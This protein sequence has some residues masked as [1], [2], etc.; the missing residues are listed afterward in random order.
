MAEVERAQVQLG[1]GA[2]LS[3]L[4][5]FLNGLAILPEAVQEIFAQLQASSLGNTQQFRAR[6]EL[7]A[8][9]FIQGFQAELAG[10]RVGGADGLAGA[11]T[12]EIFGANQQ[13]DA[14]TA[15]LRL[16]SALMEDLR[17][18][19]LPALTQPAFSAQAVQGLQAAIGGANSA[20]ESLRA[21]NSQL[22]EVEERLARLRGF[23]LTTRQQERFLTTAGTDGGQTIQVAAP[24]RR[25]IEAAG[26]PVP[27]LTSPAIQALLTTR[28]GVAGSVNLASSGR[29]LAAVLQEVAAQQA[30]VIEGEFVR[31]SQQSLA[32]ARAVPGSALVPTG[33]FT[34]S[35]PLTDQQ[36]ARLDEQLARRNAQIARRE[37]RLERI[38]EA[39][40]RSGLTDVRLGDTGLTTVVPST[41]VARSAI[42]NAE[43]RRF[44]REINTQVLQ[45]LDGQ[46]QR[47]L[48]GRGPDLSPGALRAQLGPSAF[49]DLILGRGVGPFQARRLSAEQINALING[50]ANGNQREAP[51]PRSGNR[52]FAPGLL[53]EG[54]ARAELEAQLSGFG[55]PLVTP[56][57]REI[58]ERAAAGRE[59]LN[60]QRQIRQLALT[61]GAP[62]G[63]LPVLFGQQEAVVRSALLRARAFDFSRLPRVLPPAP[64]TP[65]E[66]RAEREYEAA[67][68]ANARRRRETELRANQRLAPPLPR[69]PVPQFSN[70]A[71]Q[72]AFA[73]G[74]SGLD[75]EDLLA[76][77]TGETFGLPRADVVARGPRGGLT[78][79]V[80]PEIL[81]AYE[82]GTQ[83]AGQEAEFLARRQAELARA[84]EQQAVAAREATLAARQLLSASSGAIALPAAGVSNITS[85]VPTGRGNLAA[86]QEA[87]LLRQAER[88][89]INERSLY[90]QL[91]GAVRPASVP[92]GSIGFG[93]SFPGAF[94]GGQSFFL[95]QGIPTSI[96][97][98]VPG[99]PGTPGNP[100][101]ITTVGGASGANI[102][103]PGGGGGPA[104]GGPGGG[105]PGGP[106]GGLPGVPRGGGG[107]N[108][109]ADFRANFFDG[110]L[111][112]NDGD[113][114]RSLGQTVRFS[115]L[116]GA[117]YTALFQFT[118]AIRAGVQGAIEFEQ[119]LV[120]LSFATGRTTQEVTPFANAAAR[121]A[122]NAGLDGQL[123]VT[124]A[125][126]AV[127]LLGLSGAPLAQQRAGGLQ[128]AEIAS[129][130]AR[131]SG[132]KD[133][134]LVLTQL[135]G[136]AK[137]FGEPDL[138]KI[139]DLA[140]FI[141]RTSGT[142]PGDL[143]GA[144]AEIGG[145]AKNAGFSLAETLALISKLK[146]STA[147]T[148]NA[149]AGNLSQIFSRA[150]QGELERGL[151]EV[152]VNTF[153]TTLRDQ[154]RQLS[155]LPLT[156]EQENVLAG[157][158]GRGRSGNAVLNALREFDGITETAQRAESSSG[159]LKKA[160]DAL[161]ETLGGRLAIFAT[162]LKQLSVDIA[163]SGLLDVFAGLLIAATPLVKVLDD[164]VLA[165]DALP[166]ALRDTALA[167]GAL[168]LVAGSARARA[169]IAG[170]AT[171]LPGL[172]SGTGSALA[173]GSAVTAARGGRLAGSGARGRFLGPL[174]VL[175]GAFGLFDA[176]SS[177]SN[178]GLSLG[179]I[180]R[181]AGSGAL[182][183][184]SVGALG[185][186][187]PVVGE[188]TTLVG[189]I[190]GAIVGG[191]STGLAGLFGNRQAGN[192]GL[193]IPDL[194]RQGRLPAIA[195]GNSA[196]EAA[197][198]SV[199]GAGRSPFTTDPDD[200]GNPYYTLGLKRD[201][202]TPIAAKPRG[203]L[204]DLLLGPLGGG[205]D[206]GVT[207][208][209]DLTN[210]LSGLSARQ[211]ARLKAIADGL[212]ANAKVFQDF[213][214][215]QT[216]AQAIAE[217]SRQG[218]TGS[219]I[220]KAF[221][222]AAAAAREAGLLTNSA[223]TDFIAGVQ[224]V[225]AAVGTDAATASGNPL[226]NPL[227]Q[228]D[229]ID[230]S[231][232]Q[233]R[234]AG[235][236]SQDLAALNLV[237]RQVQDQLNA[238]D[239][240]Q[241]GA[242]GARDVSL[243][244]PDDVAGRI[245]IQLGVLQRQ[246]RD[247][248]DPG[249]QA[250]IDA[251]INDLVRQQLENSRAITT[252]RRAAGVDPTSAL[253]QARNNLR[254]AKDA[255]AQATAGQ[256]AY[257]Q[258]LRDLRAAQ[259]ALGNEELAQANRL[260]LLGIDRTNPVLVAR[261]AVRAAEDRLRR[262]RARGAGADTIAQDRLDLGDA[263]SQAEAAAFQQRFSDAQTAE[264]LGRTSHLAYISYLNNE[265]DRLTAIKNRT[266]QQQEQLNQVDQAL[267]SA[268]DQLRGQ[269]NLG[270]ITVPTPFEVR[271]SIAAQVARLPGAPQVASNVVVNISGGDLAQI[272]RTLS[273]YIGPA[274]LGASSTVTPTRI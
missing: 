83:H 223:L 213:G 231:I 101:V 8:R 174:G 117:A 164:V 234:A 220:G 129:Q 153:R 123:G 211:A 139:G 1:V 197:A 124:L 135:T 104:G 76:Y 270:D 176:A 60:I 169:G 189:V 9:A 261:A 4:E 145:L 200:P 107:R 68:A 192:D 91:R 208:T 38:L 58:R 158:F 199:T 74:R 210:Q 80:N 43:V 263:R 233:A 163:R 5:Q 260:R 105:G 245:R 24:V 182:L 3:G 198:S 35:S 121:Q 181:G 225:A 18:R 11:L 26:L 127:G 29:N 249:A 89:A 168:L 262:D 232:K 271:R 151:R 22:G 116:Y 132:A 47:D 248:R 21:L 222:E 187:L 112:K 170:A 67:E 10:A 190:G 157:K 92:T 167:I 273:E 72:L 175:G 103:P 87:D 16:V 165:F 93:P 70:P 264:Q 202:K 34:A 63:N 257:Y 161:N 110:L 41:T 149:V 162:S 212:S 219:T 180:L 65:A 36:L 147:Q 111:G 113:L 269:F 44:Q 235:A 173:A 49:E 259:V 96:P 82:Q 126:Q 31:L 240:Q 114:A 19:Q 195:G 118:Q 122:T 185:L 55:D 194:I 106:G 46:S 166:R 237:R 130:L 226:S 254:N 56:S 184:G 66:L 54:R 86:Q 172:F 131:V 15:N 100:F 177:A 159:T 52:I 57:P 230:A 221:L 108:P 144:S 64:P 20:T 84:L 266:R 40:E 268:S 152:G 206:V 148:P 85:L 215:E 246:R 247:T 39:L 125:S 272:R 250:Q 251:Q 171:L 274:A 142:A 120:T 23:Q 137:A 13:L 61:P 14:Y 109:F 37:A 201:G 216:V 207:P 94:G 178:D 102:L 98:G 191:I 71:E 150:D 141:G 77:L 119:A 73:A 134:S 30:R 241:Q 188:I 265:H 224:A 75:R 236:T 193:S 218:R 267:K 32:G 115:V 214:S 78:N 179:G 160:F 138:A 204:T 244:A 81:A 45:S 140:T 156:G 53:D 253:A 242:F 183:G 229:L 133:P 79:R 217:L 99:A 7:L 146:I 17:G 227:A 97:R 51:L 205:R 228:R 42:T 48:F 258:A 128:A 27:D 2:D 209:T 33:N 203:G 155:Q 50:T 95:G 154:L 239:S 69:F 238:I 143:L 255:L 186:P 62:V 252:A 12:R 136:V 25:V 28:G 256:P 88:Q 243:L 90:A 6:G 196:Q 59:L